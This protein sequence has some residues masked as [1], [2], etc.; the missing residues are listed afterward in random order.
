VKLEQRTVMRYFD[1]ELSDEE[2]A[3]VEA[4]LNSDPDAARLL[5]DLDRLS[6]L[7]R[8]DALTR[9]LRHDDLADAVMARLEQQSAAPASSRPKLVAPSRARRISAAVGISVAMA[10]AAAVMVRVRSLPSPHADGHGTSS[11]LIPREL[12]ASDPLA[13][14]SRF[15]EE[16]RGDAPAAAIEAVDFGAHAGSIFMV[17]EGEET[18]PVVWLVDEPGPSLGRMEPL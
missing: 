1:G 7:I 14:T 18:T 6:G 10:A 11:A 9:G 8:E 16:P 17:P 3:D 5:T 4:R 2:A 13:V 15:E 12:P